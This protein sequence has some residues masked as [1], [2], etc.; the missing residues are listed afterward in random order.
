MM[1]DIRFVLAIL[2]TV[3]MVVA[4]YP[5]VR[6]VLQRKTQPHTYTWLIW[7]I[8]QGT[9]T[10]ALWQGGGHFGAMSLIAG[11][12]LVLFVFFLSFKYGTKNITRSDTIILI[13]ALLSI[14]IWWLSDN[15]LLA[16]L[17][18]SAIDGFGYMPTYRK[19][20]QEPWSETPIFWFAM[21]VTGILALIAN[22][23]YNLIT[24]TYLATLITANIILLTLLLIRRRYV[25]QP[26]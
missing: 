25:P 23:E 17:M 1:F 12:L 20:Y 22:A 21:I 24:V 2:S 16:V 4:Y 10:V 7:A 18:V 11:T 9:A 26:K 8:T 15:P 3:I 13:L 5:Y 19:S 6:D 14:L